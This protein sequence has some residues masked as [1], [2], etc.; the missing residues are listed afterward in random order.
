MNN[1]K[2]LLTKIFLYKKPKEYY[3]FSLPEN[4][5]INET[6][7]PSD[8]DKDLKIY[9]DLNKN[10]DY[11]KVKYNTLIN[12]DIKLR[13]F[14]LNINNKEHNSLLVFIDGMINSNSINDFILK[15]IMKKDA[16]R[17]QKNF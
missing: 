2:N 1:L 6:A 8:D 13:S 15:P 5:N 17:I 9:S 4:S 16:S 12:S 11:L 10:I 14:K 3:E 7:I